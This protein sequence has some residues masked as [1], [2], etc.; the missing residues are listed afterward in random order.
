MAVIEV[1]SDGSLGFEAGVQVTLPDTIAAGRAVHV[2]IRTY[3][4]GCLIRDPQRGGQTFVNVKG[5]E[6]V[7][8]PWD[9]LDLGP[10]SPTVNWNCAGVLTYW[11]RVVPVVFHER[12][13]ATVA[14]RGISEDTYP[15][16]VIEVVFR[17]EVV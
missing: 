7:I 2:R 1:G 15:S 16:R 10:R 9:R 14:I 8:I 11:T 3:G 6:V 5:R 12:G 4:G 17:L 13:T